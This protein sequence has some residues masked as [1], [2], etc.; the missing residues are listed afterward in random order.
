[1]HETGDKNTEGA[2][3]GT[4]ANIAMELG[5][6]DQAITHLNRSLQ[7]F[8]DLGNKRWEGI[9]LGNLGNAYQNQAHCNEALEYYTQAIRIARAIGDRNTECINLGNL[10]N[11]FHSQAQYDHALKQLSNR[12]LAREIGNPRYESFHLG[13]AAD[14]YFDR[15]GIKKPWT[16]SSRGFALLEKMETPELRARFLETKATF[17]QCFISP[18]G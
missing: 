3:L 1:M 14:V 15:R 16:F 2:T 5:Q 4:L 7:I 10:G 18:S 6:Y 9:N 8:R 13:N 17:L 12:A 11:V